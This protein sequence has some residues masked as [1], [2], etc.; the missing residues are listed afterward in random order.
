M[1]IKTI[2]KYLIS[3][4]KHNKLCRI[5]FKVLGCNV[6]WVIN[7]NNNSLDMLATDHDILD[8]YLDKKY[9]LCDPNVSLELNDKKSSWQITIGTDCDEFN[10]SGFLYDL[11]KIF[12]VEEFVSIEKKVRSERYC[13]RFFTKNNRFVFMNQLINNTLLIKYFIGFMSKTFKLDLNKQAK[14]GIIQLK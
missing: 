14:L 11:Y 8:Y 13:F 12:N 1:I 2:N 7:L 4:N 9:Y 3:E 6:L 10:K 5:I